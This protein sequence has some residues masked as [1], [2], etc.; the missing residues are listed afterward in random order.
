MSRLLQTESNVS[1]ADFAVLVT[2]LRGWRGGVSSYGRSAL[3]TRVA[4]SC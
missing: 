2:T 4:R 3:V 1:T